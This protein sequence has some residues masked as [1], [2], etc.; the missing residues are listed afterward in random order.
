MNQKKMEAKSLFYQKRALT[1][2]ASLPD[3]EKPEQIS[4][5]LKPL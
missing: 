2:I 4:V 1:P 3:Q 5:Q